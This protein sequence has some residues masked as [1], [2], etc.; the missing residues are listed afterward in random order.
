LHLTDRDLVVLDRYTWYDV[1]GEDVI[2]A[3]EVPVFEND[4]EGLGGALG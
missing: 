3:G 4:V 1:V 2:R